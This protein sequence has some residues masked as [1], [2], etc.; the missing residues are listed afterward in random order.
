MSARLDGLALHLAHSRGGRRD[1]GPGSTW[2]SAATG[3]AVGEP[4]ARYAA[5]PTLDP[6]AIQSLLAHDWRARREIVQPSRDLIRAGVE[7]SDLPEGIDQAAIQSWL[8]GDETDGT[9]GLLDGISNLAA[10]N[11]AHG[12]AV[13]VAVCEDGRHPSEPVDLARLERVISWETLDR[14]SVMPYRSSGRTLGPV[15]YWVIGGTGQLDSTYQIVHPSRVAVLW[16]DWMPAS[17][18][19]RYLGWGL[20]RLEVLR[21]Q[22]DTLALGHAH[23]GRLLTRTSQDVLILAEAS[24]HIDEV[25][26]NFVRQRLG[27]L[28]TQANSGGFLTIDGGIEGDPSKGQPG[29]RPDDFKTLSRPL[30]GAR[31]IVDAQHDDWR[32]GTSMPRVVADGEVSAGINSGE[33]AGEWRAWAGVIA[34]EQRTVTS[35]LNWGL[36]LIFA[37]RQGPTS[38]QVPATWTAGWQP[39]AEADRMLEADVS[40]KEAAADRLYVDAG[41]LRPEEVRQHR[42]V[43]GKRGAVV[44]EEA[45][46]LPQPTA[47]DLAAEVAA[48]DPGA[49][50]AEGGGDGS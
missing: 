7:I 20:S 27:A 11:W 12:G 32:R 46:L 47:E 37:S 40:A 49:E 1:A 22:R 28:Q 45:D 26:E 10:E 48:L 16:G 33:G 29:R 19:R 42:H 14:Y 38:G 24:E 4:N 2:E 15:D 17:W 35:A 50:L 8:E 41:V 25:G 5:G 18:R 43:D 13:L 9:P 34:G 44:V 23:L 6:R 39:L 3:G 36:G 31:D 21:D 30:G